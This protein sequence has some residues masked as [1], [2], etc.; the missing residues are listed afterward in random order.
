MFIGLVLW[1]PSFVMVWKETVAMHCALCNVTRDGWYLEFM[2]TKYYC[3]LQNV[4]SII[5]ALFSDCLSCLRSIWERCSK[6]GTLRTL[7]HFELKWLNS[8]CNWLMSCSMYI[9]DWIDVETISVLTF[10]HVYYTHVDSTFKRVVT[11]G[12]Y[13]CNGYLP[14]GVTLSRDL[15]NEQVRS[16]IWSCTEMQ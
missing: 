3:S 2:M 9:H 16:L 7:E 1:P 5:I 8:Y 12:N 15:A 6:L 11:Y 13:Y 4:A 10:P 14:P